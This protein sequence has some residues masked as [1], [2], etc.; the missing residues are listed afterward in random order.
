M[1]K[2]A[3]RKTDI[4]R[5]I[6]LKQKEAQLKA[7]IQRVENRAKSQDRKNDT[8]CKIIIGGAMLADAVIRPETTK[9]L[10]AVLGRAVTNERD[11]ALLTTMFPKY[12]LKT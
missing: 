3:P 10:L 7:Q 2:T 5:L 1:P 6:V 11:K 9:F 8:R 12:H 4:E